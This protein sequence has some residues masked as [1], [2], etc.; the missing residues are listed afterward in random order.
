[1]NGPCPH[2]PACPGCDL[3]EL[4]YDEQLAL[5]S[6]RTRE[7]LERWEALR[8]LPIAPCIGAEQRTGWRTRSKWAVEGPRIGLFGPGH[9]VVDTPGCVVAAPAAL[10]IAERL[11]HRPPER[12]ARLVALD[13]RVSR[14]GDAVPVLVVEARDADAAL[15]HAEA[16]ADWLGE[17]E[18]ARVTGVAASWRRPGAPTTLGG[19][20]RT[21]CGETV[22]EDCVGHKP[23]LFPAGSFSQPHAAQTEALQDLIAEALDRL[24]HEA[25]KAE[26][27]DLY[28]GTGGLG[29]S[30]AR[31]VRR[32]TLVETNGPATDAARISAERLAVGDR[33]RALAMPAEQA[34]AELH[35]G[36]PLVVIV[37][38]PRTGLAAPVLAA[39]VR[40]RPELLVVVSCDPR[41]LA[42]DL[43]LLAPFGLAAGTVR[44][45]DLQPGTSQVECVVALQPAEP[46]PVRTIAEG[47]GWVVVDKPP[48]MPTIPHPEWPASLL[49]LVR[50]LLPRAHAVHR[51]DG[52]TSGLVLVAEPGATAPDL[53][54]ST[55]TYI[56]LAKGITHKAG[57]LRQELFDDGRPVEAETRYRRV[58]VVGGHSL[59]E[60]E[61][62]TGRTHQIRRHLAG[63]GHPVLGDGRY[64]DP[65][66]NRHMDARHGLVRPFLHAARIAT[67]HG[68]FE[69]PLWP[70]LTATLESLR[71]T[72][73][74]APRGRPGGRA[75]RPGHRG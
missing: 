18:G 47:P 56:A 30:L 35:P 65:A 32:V 74:P 51:L 42:R 2:R 69:S 19:M 62:V 7:A 44:P 6:Q 71:A 9:A 3:F 5:K 24:G 31:R 4:S 54:R 43:G 26:L 17:I 45:L 75:R 46:P 34:L 33:V 21:L 49:A 40:L 10:A 37:D 22:I 14:D 23:L 57:A 53:E 61:L 36:R 48:L 73:G 63:V 15:R 55:K 29:L 68:T 25:R 39:L 27:I 1:M 28:A 52:G 11:R 20:P 60:V 66:S 8:S 16:L 12:G 58:D 70:D 59:L 67:P 41:T 64:G 50:R 38:P 72:P 13:V